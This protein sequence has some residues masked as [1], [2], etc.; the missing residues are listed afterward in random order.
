MLPAKPTRTDVLRRFRAGQDGTVAVEF[1]LIAP[2]LLFLLY[3]TIELTDAIAAKRRVTMAVSTMADL[4]TNSRHDWVHEDTVAD[5]M[6]ATARVLEP[7][8]VEGALLRLTCVT[9]NE[10]EDSQVVVWSVERSG[11]GTVSE[12]KKTGYKRGDEFKA[13][14]DKEILKPNE[15]LVTPDYHM[16]VGQ[17][18]YTYDPPIAEQLGTFTIAQHEARLPRREEYVHLCESNRPGP[19]CTDGRDWLE[20]KDRPGAQEL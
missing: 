17:I 15:H 10:D 16:I 13:L 3:G 11:S 8:G 14:G 2:V 5:V 7:Y 20:N 9:W 6:N 1:A 19:D 12:T 4:V 18:I